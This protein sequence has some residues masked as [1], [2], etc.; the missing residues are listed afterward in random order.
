MN[1]CPITYE[2]TE[3]I[4]SLKGLKKLNRNLKT[5]EPILFSSSELRTKASVAMLNLS[6]PGFQPKLPMRINIKEGKFEIGLKYSTFILKPQNGDYA[7]LPENEDLTMKLAATVGIET[8]F[9]CLLHAKQGLVYVIKRFDRYGKNK[10]LHIE[11]FAQLSGK[12][13]DEKYGSS[14]KEV[15][16]VI[17]KYCTFPAIEK[18]K[19]FRLV[20]FSYLVG[21]A[22][23]HLKNFSL[24]IDKG[25]VVRLSPAYDLLSTAIVLYNQKEEIGLS[26]NGKVQGLAREDF[27]DHFGETVLGINKKMLEKI[28][29]EFISVTETW[30][31]IIN[32]SFLPEK[33]QGNYL[34][35]IT[36]RAYNV[37][38]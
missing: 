24:I 9:H 38:L 12:T 27:F 35:F 6:I 8:P 22:D 13:T 28:K 3:S 29:Q 30:S 26:L 4:Y 1:K 17:D 36:K 19:L 25:G 34:R 15:A 23:N 11:D 20:L 31:N 10:K 7:Y 32:K 5:L 2:D 14:M 16:E 18:V 33:V 21:N 37:I